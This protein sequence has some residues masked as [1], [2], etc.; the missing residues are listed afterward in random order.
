MKP[1]LLSF[2]IGGFLFTSVNVLSNEQVRE[3]DVNQLK[4]IRNVSQS[5]LNVRG[6]ERKEI[7]AETMVLRNEINN[8]RE[9]L[10]KAIK[11]IDKPS[12]TVSSGFKITSD[13]QASIDLASKET[14]GQSV[15]RKTKLMFTS[16]VGGEKSELPKVKK[17]DKY[18]ML[19]VSAKNIMS[20][21][22]RKVEE[23]LPS[24]WEVWKKPSENNKNLS[25]VL[26][27]LVKDIEVLENADTPDKVAKIKMILKR[28]DLRDDSEDKEISPTLTTMTKHY[29]K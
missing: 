4:M 14:V 13:A 23:G 2:L 20:H 28:L 25:R 15:W 3:F 22:Q 6:Q 9:L 17:H 19:I 24:V 7:V 21:R 5:I 26:G 12:M 11:S 1:A 8:T 10:K 18:N 16:Y 29:H 27:V